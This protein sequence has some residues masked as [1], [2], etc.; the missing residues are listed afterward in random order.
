M[1]VVLKNSDTPSN[2]IVKSKDRVIIKL[3]SEFGELNY[4]DHL[5]KN[6]NQNPKYNV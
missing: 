1:L 4:L 5:A 6:A 2:V 3:V